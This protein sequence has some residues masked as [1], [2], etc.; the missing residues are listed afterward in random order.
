M[1]FASLK[2]VVDIFATGHG[3]TAAAA[4]AAAAGSEQGSSI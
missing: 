2:W 4:A 3:K 1:T